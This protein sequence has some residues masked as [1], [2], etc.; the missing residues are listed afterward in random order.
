MGH[1]MENTETKM[2]STLKKMAKV[3]RMSNGNHNN[4]ILIVLMFSY[5]LYKF[6]FKIFF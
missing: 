6:I 2:D 1:E 4:I 5:A 3:L